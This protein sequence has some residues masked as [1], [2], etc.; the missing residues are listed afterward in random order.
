[1]DPTKFTV[2]A[3]S[4]GGFIRST[5]EDLALELIDSGPAYGNYIFFYAELS[6][7]GDE[8]PNVES[9]A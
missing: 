3:L 5:T 1:M 9:T 8:I 2:W 4:P 7:I 6:P